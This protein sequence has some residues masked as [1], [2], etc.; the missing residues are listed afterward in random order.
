[1]CW[2]GPASSFARHTMSANS[3]SARRAYPRTVRLAGSCP[4]KPACITSGNVVATVLRG[5]VVR[6]YCMIMPSAVTGSQH[7]WLSLCR[8]VQSLLPG[9]APAPGG[10]RSRAST[11]PAAPRTLLSSSPCSG[12]YVPSS[13]QTTTAYRSRWVIPT[14]HDVLPF[15]LD[16]L[17]QRCFVRSRS[18][19]KNRGS[20]QGQVQI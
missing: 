11:V 6:E 7:S 4:G 15:L 3:R 9:H 18:S 16:F 12:I 17:R 1:M 2:P 5:A 19:K 10:G 14:C 8:R 20:L 13:V